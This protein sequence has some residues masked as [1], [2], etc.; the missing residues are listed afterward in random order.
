MTF[1]FNYQTIKHC[2]SLY[3][4]TN[5][6]AVAQAAAQAVSHPPPPPGTVDH[7]QEHD[8]YTFLQVDNSHHLEDFFCGGNLSF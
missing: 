6:M 3:P 1:I 8:L 2:S 4:A 5:P 7:Q